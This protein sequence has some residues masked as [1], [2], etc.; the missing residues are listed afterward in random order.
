[1]ALTAMKDILAKAEKGGF[2]VGAFSVADMEMILGAVRAAEELNMPMILQ[3]AQS[4][5][6]YSPLDKLAP[7]MLAAARNCKAEVA[8]HFDHGTDISVIHEALELGFTSVMIDASKYDIEG[9]IKLTKQVKKMADEYN[10]TVEAEVGQLGVGEDGTHDSS[11]IHSDPLEVKRLYEETGVDAIALSI[12]NQHGF[13]KDTPKLRFDILE[14]ANS[15]VPVP[16]VLHGGSGISDADF[17]KC[18]RLGITK[19]NVA[20]ATFSAVKNA[21]KD[22]LDSGRTTDYFILSSAMADAA[23]ENIKRHMKVFSMKE[24]Y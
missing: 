5:L 16:L 21:A 4:R 22:C 17:Q 11:K 7:M 13:Y 23:Y 9:N 12:G 8:V 15:L 24:T 10:A 19:I 20:T 14:E 1:M 18:I 2:G 3:V 6:H